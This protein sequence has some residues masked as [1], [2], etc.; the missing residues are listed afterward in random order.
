MGT[1]RTQ[2]PSPGVEGHLPLADRQLD[3]LAS[4]REVGWEFTGLSPRVQVLRGTLHWPTDSK[5]D[6]PVERKSDGKIQDSVPESR[7]CEAPYTGRRTVRQT[8]QWKD[9]RMGKYRTQPPS[10][11]VERHLTLADRQ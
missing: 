1:Y 2:P 5:T 10:P 9:S 6:W 4:G 3:R 11:G 7:C 8:G